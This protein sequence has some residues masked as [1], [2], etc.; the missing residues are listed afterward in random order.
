MHGVGQ[1]WKDCLGR[2]ITKNGMLE[3][4]PRATTEGVEN[5]IVTW[6]NHKENHVE[7]LKMQS[8]LGKCYRTE[9][10]HSPASIKGQ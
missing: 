4:C 3:R 6:R 8:V 5:G 10:V 2:I 9:G 7:T 1:G